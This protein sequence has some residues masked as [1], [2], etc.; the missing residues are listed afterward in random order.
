MVLALVSAFLTSFLPIINKRLLADIPVSVVAWGVNALSLPI[1]GSVALVLFPLPAVDRVFWLGV[2]GSALLNLAATVAST[3]ALK[4]GEASLVTPVLTFNPAFTL[5]IASVTL[6]EIPRASGVLGVLLVLAG[7]Y[8]LN[9]RA[10]TSGWWRPLVVLVTEPAM[11]LAVLASF[12]WGLT[13]IA[14]KVAIQHTQ[15]SNPPLVAF[16]STALMV[17]FLVPGLRRTGAHPRQHLI[18][19]WPGFV[20]GAL[21]AGIAP[22]FGFTAISLGLVGYVS[23]IFKLSAV[24]SILWAALFLREDVTS[25]R[26]IGALMMVLGA[27]VLGL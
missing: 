24:L 3:Q 26:L 12:L 8:V 2:L 27:V 25:N 22:I 17:L 19:R 6:G 20:Q 23:A 7:G 10:M 5:L 15:P 1:L 18:A 14:E 9:L 11:A 4:L 16:G 21:I 13:P